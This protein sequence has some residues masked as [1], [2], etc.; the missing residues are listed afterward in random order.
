MSSMATSLRDDVGGGGGGARSGGTAGFPSVSTYWQSLCSHSSTFT[1]QQRRVCVRFPASM[2]FVYMGAGHAI[3]ECKRQFY[4]HRWNCSVEHSLLRAAVASGPAPRPR[5]RSLGPA[6]TQPANNA[7]LP[8]RRPR[9][10]R[11]DSANI[12]NQG[13]LYL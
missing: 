6:D 7:S 4:W 1:S 8:R 13:T 12:L 10:Q 3:R 2:A 9:F 5:G 11:I